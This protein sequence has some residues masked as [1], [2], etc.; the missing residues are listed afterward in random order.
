[1]ARGRH[2]LLDG[3]RL[4]ANREEADCSFATVFSAARHY[5]SGRLPFL[6]GLAG[7]SYLLAGYAT[8]FDVWL[9]D[10]FP[11]EGCS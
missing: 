1:M 8:S 6:V 7:T 10:S 5:H 2:L 9:M 3:L 4:G 11:A